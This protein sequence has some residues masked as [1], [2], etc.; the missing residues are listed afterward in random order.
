MPEVYT[1]APLQFEAVKT[2]DLV[3]HVGESDRLTVTSVSP[4]KVEASCRVL[5]DKPGEWNRP[6]EELRRG[7]EVTRKQS[8]TVM[9]NTENTFTVIGMNEH[10]IVGERHVT[11]TATEGWLKVARNSMTPHITDTR[12]QV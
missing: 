5:I 3:R 12:F 8:P 7:E 1:R 10:G 9:A 4:N 11:I 6:L 2:D